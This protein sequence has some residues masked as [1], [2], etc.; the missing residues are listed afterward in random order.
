MKVLLIRP[1]VPPQT[2]GLSNVMICEPLE[3]EY[4]AAGVDDDEVQ[5]LDL[6]IE[7]GL[8]KRLREFSPDVV[9]LSCYITGVNEVIKI[10]R[11]VKRWNRDCLTVVGG[12]HASVAPEDFAD[13]SVDSIALGDGTALMPRLLDAWGNGRK[14]EGLPGI[15]IPS[16]EGKVYVTREAPYMTAPDYLPHPRRDLT[17]HLRHRYYYLFHQPVATMKTTWGCWYDCSFCMTWAVTGGTVF[18]RSAESIVREIES[19]KEPEIYIVDDI[20]LINSPRLR[21]IAHLLRTNGIHKH[22]LVY[23]RADYIADNEDVIREWS[24]V[25][26]R[27]VIVGLEAATSEELGQV[28]K[29]VTADQNRLCVEVL[30]RNGVDIYASLIPQPWY[31]RKDWERLYAYIEKLGIYYVNI[32]PLTPL[33]GSAMFSEYEDRITV[34]R[35]AHPLW[36]LTHVVLPTQ[37][38]LKDYYRQLLRLYARTVLSVRRAARLT[39]RTRPPV[40]SPKYLRLW[41]GAVRIFFQFINA[42]KHHSGKRLERSLDRGPAVPGLDYRGAGLAIV[43]NQPTMTRRGYSERKPIDPY[44]GYLFSD[45]ERKPCNGLLDHPLARKWRDVVSWGI[46]ESLYTYQQP[47]QSKAGPLQVLNGHTYRMISSYDYLGLRGHPAI[48]KAAHEAIERYGTGTGGVRLLTGSTDLHYELDETIAKFKGVE[49]SLSF[50]SGYLANLAV[51]S[52]L[53]RPGDRIVSDARAHRSLSDACKLA[54]VEAVTFPHND[55]NRLE[56]LLRQSRDF[57]RTLIIVEGVYSMDGDICPLPEIIDLKKKYSCHLMVDEAHSFGCLGATGRG[58]DEYFGVSA[59]DVDVWMGTLS[60]AIPSTGGFIAGSMELII[61]LQHGSGPFMFSA[62]ASPAL[63]ASALEAIEVIQQ[64]PER[65]VRLRDN[66]AYLRRHLKQLGYDTGDTESHIIPVILGSD[67]DAYKFSHA[68]FER[69][70]IALAVVPP[71][72]SPGA[73]RLRIC[74]TAS[75]DRDFLEKVVADFAACRTLL[76]PSVAHGGH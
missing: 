67:R 29:K 54:R 70:T 73:A 66:A 52:A 25:G 30:R 65:Q 68:L 22:F 27:A 76:S 43:D 72:V 63:V 74:A 33:P 42:H 62:A 6:I 4:L 12:V 34:P 47:Y 41:M 61:Y 75:Y 5:I 23:G 48:E 44:H 11:L 56:D 37:D 71:A 53:F 35:R 19:I 31:R 58:V 38:T 8:E 10:C 50:S 59:A 20:F 64:E 9:G 7:R 28:G 21:E 32:S 36:D 60:K 40:W 3:L 13:P 26:L 55:L 39:L 14:L 46:R 24:E 57:R 17:A 51:I 1:P 45:Q 15:A 2:I 69:G 16:G 49:A 18:S